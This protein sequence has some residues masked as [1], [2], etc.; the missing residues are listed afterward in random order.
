MER[1]SPNI[2]PVSRRHAESVLFVVKQL[3]DKVLGFTEPNLHVLTLLGFRAL[4]RAKIKET[5]MTTKE[6]K[7][8]AIQANIDKLCEER[9]V[10]MGD[11]HPSAD[12]SK[13]KQISKLT[14]QITAKC[15]ER[16][17]ARS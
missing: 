2:R 10:V 5:V 12:G 3:P 4:R 15:E 8:T 6:E 14:E 7:I 17:K 11:P 1:E 16:E 13:E 9:D